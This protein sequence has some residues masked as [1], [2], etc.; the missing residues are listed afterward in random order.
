MT[1]LRLCGML[2]SMISFLKR[3]GFIAL[4]A[5]SFALASCSRVMGYGMLLWDIP[6]RDLQDG[7]IIPVY[8]RSNISHTYAVSAP[9]SKERF[10]IPLW[11]ITPP[12]SRRSLKKTAAQYAEF[13]HRYAS[14]KLDGLPIR[15]EPVNTARQVY[16]LRKGE[17]IKIL[18]KGEGQAVMVG[19]DALEGNWLRVLTS[20]GT[21]G[22]CFSYNLELFETQKGGAV[23]TGEGSGAE[24]TDDVFETL[25][26]TVWYPDYYRAMIREKR[27][28][29]LRMNAAYCFTVDAENRKVSMNLPERYGS[30]EYGEALKT[31]DGEYTFTDTPVKVSVKSNYIAVTCAD[32]A[33]RPHDYNF[34]SLGDDV[35]IAALVAEEKERRDAEYERI[36]ASGPNFKSAAYGQLSLKRDG[37]F[38]WRGNRRLVPSLIAESAKGGGTAEIDYFIDSSLS[39]QYDGVLSFAFEGMK[40]KVNFLYKI[41]ANGVRFEDAS[42]AR[43]E[44]NTLVR[45]G[46]SPLV[47]FFEKN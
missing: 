35:D 24:E 8:I 42:E 38:T 5:L 27:I 6:E 13:L 45:R 40:D 43:F 11:Q 34:I 7:D 14:V 9:G 47:I 44:G 26:A 36:A 12:A 4:C 32:D 29:P 16:R 28:D 39:P 2:Y 33:G 22:W 19:S 23:E 21:Q 10:D 15:A 17:I 37:S 1:F 18:Y 46:A 31:A 41:E 30:W 3:Y 20:S 25:A